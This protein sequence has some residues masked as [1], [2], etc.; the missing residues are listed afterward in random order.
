LYTRQLHL[1]LNRLYWL[2]DSGQPS[3]PFVM[4]T[5]VRARRPTSPPPFNSNPPYAPPQQTQRFPHPKQDHLDADERRAQA[6]RNYLS[7]R[8]P[9]PPGG[10]N[11][12]AGEWKLLLVVVIV[13]CAVRM[14]RI[15]KPNS[16]VY[17]ALSAIR[18]AINLSSVGL[19]RSISENSHPSILKHNILWM[20]IPHWLNF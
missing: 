18:L 5:S 10:L 19:T 14:F 4:A 1:Q 16:V 20:S 12:T 11:I 17:V 15:S 9:H 13:A 3:A 6:S 2:E 7:G 8:H